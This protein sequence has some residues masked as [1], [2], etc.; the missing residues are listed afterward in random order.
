MQ[1]VFIKLR[2]NFE[3][4][5]AS[6]FFTGGNQNASTC[7]ISRFPL[8]TRSLRHFS[9]TIRSVQAAKVQSMMGMGRW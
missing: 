2:L 6:F 9:S 5:F 7:Q 8:T 3:C 1:S 4:V